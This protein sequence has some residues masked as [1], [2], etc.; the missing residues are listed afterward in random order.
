MLSLDIEIDEDFEDQEDD[1][2]EFETWISRKHYQDL[3]YI[4]VQKKKIK[5]SVITVVN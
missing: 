5:E 1:T 4:Q 3:K 2:K